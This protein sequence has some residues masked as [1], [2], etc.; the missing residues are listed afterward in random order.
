MRA[1]Q[2]GKYR[3]KKSGNLVYTYALD[4]NEE[5]TA[6]YK[7]SKG[8][9]YVEDDVT[10]KP[11]LFTNKSV[12]KQCPVIITS[13]GEFRLDNSSIVEAAQLAN[14]LGGAVADAIAKQM[15]QGLGIDFG[16]SKAAEA[17]VSKPDTVE[18]TVEDEIKDDN[19]PF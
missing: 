6:Q 4:L 7:A 19:A 8:E 16:N 12:G 3:S 11:L 18:N 17:P 9:Y 15:M 14:D 5:Q 13:A 2:T 1:T 10:G